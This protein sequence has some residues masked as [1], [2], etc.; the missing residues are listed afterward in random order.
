MQE[1]KRGEMEDGSGMV[2]EVVVCLAAR[3]FMSVVEVE[4]LGMLF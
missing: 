2:K 4:C 1:K 3:F